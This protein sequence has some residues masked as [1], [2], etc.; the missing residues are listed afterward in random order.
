[1]LGR[2][3]TVYLANGLPSGIRHVEIA[4]WSGQGIACPRSRL[5]DLGDWS[6]AAR[7]SVYFL[8]E[9]DSG[10]TGDRVYIGE[11][12]NVQR[13][14][15]DHFRNKDFWNEA[16]LF[17]SKDDNL[18]KSHVMYLESRLTQIGIAAARFEVEAGKNPTEASLPRADRDAMEEF[19]SNVQIVLGALGHRVLESVN[20]VFG[21][22][23]QVGDQVELVSYRFFFSVRDLRA[24]GRFTDEGFVLLAGSKLSGTTSESMP[25][26]TLAIRNS[27]VAEGILEPAGDDYLLKSDQVVSSSSY[28]AAIVAGTSRSGPQSWLDAN[29]RSLKQIEQDLASDI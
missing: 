2:K 3:L 25:G 23:T 5:K 8:L 14:L 20:P 1:M 24:E 16:V 21:D 11:S 13:R 17:T 12:E 27:W 29:S 26:K 10:D 6:E 9:K 15:K 22:Q 4:N 18:T 19:L 28:A 7:P